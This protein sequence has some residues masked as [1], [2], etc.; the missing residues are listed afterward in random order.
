MSAGAAEMPERAADLA[1]Y[2]PERRLLLSSAGAGWSGVQAQLFHMRD[3]GRFRLSM[4]P[5]PEDIITVQTEGVTRLQGKVVRPYRAYT[6]GPG[7]IIIL[8]QGEPSDWEW[9][10][11]CQVLCLYLDPA[12]LAEAYRAITGREPGHVELIARHNHEDPLIHQLGLALQRELAAPGPAS[13]LYVESL[14]QALVIHLLRTGA[15]ARPQPLPARGGLAPAALRQVL[16]YIEAH[17]AGDLSQAAVAAVAGV[18][19]YHFARQ[20]RRST[21]ETLHRY[22]VERRLEA[23][24]RLLGEGRSSVVEVAALAGFAD[25]SHLHRLF[26]ARFGVTPGAML[27][28]RTKIQPERTDLQDQSPG[29]PLL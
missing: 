22:V 20:F 15:A 2:S 16:E 24:R 12:F 10:T 17:L 9:T 5:A 27:G 23:A 8:P 7:D 25:Q 14:A 13:R 11:E 1:A 21:G 29:D 4:P 3:V 26:K 28:Q 18:S 6:A 19:Q